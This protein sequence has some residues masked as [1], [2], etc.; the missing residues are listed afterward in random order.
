M[1]APPAPDRRRLLMALGLGG[2]GLMSSRALAETPPRPNVEDAPPGHAAEAARSVPFFGPHQAGI[3]TP[4]PAAGLVAAFDVVASSLDEVE[5][6]LRLL[7]QRA[8]F[9]TQDRKSVV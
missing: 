2:I 6:M 5:A 9:L 3:V 1:T 8:A 7:T 4:R